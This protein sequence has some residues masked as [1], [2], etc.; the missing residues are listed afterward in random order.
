MEEKKYRKEN[1]VWTVSEDYSKLPATNLF[2]LKGQD[3]PY[4][5]KMTLLGSVYKYLNVEALFDFLYQH[6]PNTELKNEF[7]KIVEIYLDDCLNKKMLEDRPGIKSIR[8]KYFNSKI[9]YYKNNRPKDVEDEIEYAYYSSLLG[10][11]AHSREAVEKVVRDLHFNNIKFDTKYIIKNLNAVFLKYFYVNIQEDKN[12]EEGKFITKDKKI[13]ENDTK[14]IKDSK[15]RIDF[16]MLKSLDSKKREMTEEFSLNIESAEFTNQLSESDVLFDDKDSKSQNNVKYTNDEKIREMVEDRFGISMISSYV[17]KSIENKFCTGIHKGINFLMTEGVFNDRV[18]SKY[19]KN[20]IYEQRIKNL[21]YFNENELEFRRTIS[22]LTTFLKKKINHD[23]L[24]TILKIKQGKLM[25]SQ[26]WRSNYLND[27]NIFYNKR[28]DENATISVDILLDSSASQLGREESISA[29]AYI[30]SQTMSNLDIACRVIA[31][32]NFFNYLVFI[33]FRDYKEPKSFNNKIFDFKGAGSNRDGLAIKI[34][35]KSI[36]ENSYDRKILI[37]LS[38]GKPNNVID[39]KSNSF[40]KLDALDYEGEDAVRNTQEEVFN[41]KLNDIHI[42]GIFTGEEEDLP[43]EK[44]IY[45]K[46]FAYIK[47]IKR[48]SKI[49]GFYLSQVINYDI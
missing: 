7:L 34:L 13:K 11:Y 9:N 23:E 20:Q 28:M 31:Y 17:S 27:N 10:H 49:I 22:E 2:D 40:I 8:E 30:I 14:G 36:I 21:N 5:Y 4:I 44:R 24:D 6:L 26:V 33:K 38:D 43:T 46:D 35:N 15:P 19:F 16:N 37:I 32:S 41:G 39:L 48:F 42:L 29:Q 45:G 1:I 3:E 25:S 18:N 47:N 12:I